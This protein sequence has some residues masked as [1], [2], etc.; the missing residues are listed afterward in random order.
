VTISGGAASGS[1]GGY[2]VS[3]TLGQTYIGSIAT[4]GGGSQFAADLGFWEI[5]SVPLG[6]PPVITFAP[7]NQLEGIGYSATFFAA[8]KGAPPLAYQWQHNGVPIAGANGTSFN[9]ASVQ[10]NDAGT[11]TFVVTDANGLTN[12][13]SATLT[14]LPFTWSTVVTGLSPTAVAADPSGNLFI[15][16]NNNVIWKVAAGSGGAPVPFAG[17]PNHAGS[18]DGTGGDARFN[19]PQGIVAD[20]AGNLYVTDS[21]NDT[22]RKITPAGVVTTLA[23]QAGQAGFINGINN[24]NLFN[25]PMGLGIDAANN[26]YVSDR[27]DGRIC[28][29]SPA[30]TIT[31][32]LDNY[33][34][35][36]FSSTWDGGSIQG[37]GGVAADAGGD[38]Y[39]ADTGGQLIQ[40]MPAGDSP[41]AN[42]V[43]GLPWAPANN[44]TY[45][46]A[47]NNDGVGQAA[48]FDNPLGI[49]V[50]GPG[51]IYVTDV[52]SST[53]R[54]ITSG[55]VVST[56][57]GS[58][59]AYPRLVDG[60]GNTALFHAP[61]WVTLDKWGN[62]YVADTDNGAIRQSHWGAPTGPP[63]IT[64]QPVSQTGQATYT[65]ITFG[66]GIYG[67]APFT[68]QWNFNGT[69][70]AGATGS[71]YILSPVQ[72]A[73]AGNYSVTVANANGSVTSASA[74]LTVNPAY[75]WSTVV[76][77]IS[78]TAVAEDAAGNLYIADNNS[79][80]WKV[81]AGSGGA[82]VAWAGRYGHSGSTDGAGGDAR[83][84]SPQGIA[85]DLAGNVYV[86]DSGNNTIRLITP[87][88]VVTTVAG[89]ASSAGFVDASG[90][91]ARFNDPL[92]LTLDSQTNIYVADRYN[93]AIRKIAPSGMVT[94]LSTGF[95]DGGWDG[96]GGPGPGAVAVDSLGNVYVADTGGQSVRVIAPGGSVSQFAGPTSTVG[97]YADGVGQY[98]SLDN[99][100]GITLDASGNLYVSDARDSTIRRI[101][102]A[103][104]MTT[105]GGL[106]TA[107]PR[108]VD[109]VGSGALFHAPLGLTMDHLGNLYVAD[110]DNGAIRLGTLGAPTGPP[111]IT[112][113]PVSQTGQATYTTITF[114]VGVYGAAPFT[115]Q[116]YFNG[117]PIAGATGSNYILSPVQL[118]NAGTY[119]VTV[120]NANGSVNSTN[121]TLTVNPAYTWS[122]LFSGLN[123][124]AMPTAVAEDAAGNLYIAD[125]NSVIWKVAAGAGGAPVAWA[126]RYGHSGSTD[127]TGGDARFNSPQ[128]IA[129]DN[130]G[131][132]YVADSGNNTIRRI[133][134]AG[135]VTTLAGVAGT[136]A[137]FDG[138]GSAALFNDPLGLTVDSQANVYVADR[139]NGAIRKLAPS[140]AVTTVAGSFNSPAGVAVDAGGSLY[141]VELGNA[142]I[143][144]ISPGGS[145]RLL[146]GP[147]PPQG[148]YTD[149][150]GQYAGFDNPFGITL[151]A[152][153]YVYVSDPR[154]STIR[155]LDPARNV[156]TLGGSP[157]AYPRLVDGVGSGALFHAPLGLTM[158]H[159][160]NLY[161]AD[162]DN[163]AIR[164]GTLGAPTGPPQITSQ[165]VS[166]TGQATYTTITFGV[167]VYGAAPFTYQW[168]F[169]GTP[170]PGATGSNYILS[171]VQLANAG[172]YSVTVANANGSVTSASATLSVNP[173]YTWSTVIGG[174]SPKAVAPDGGGNL[175]I[176]DGGNVIW[177][178]AAGGGGVPVAFAGLLYHAGSADGT[179]ANARFN[180]P[181]G[182]AVDPAGNVYVAD[183]GNNTIRMITPAGAVTT[184]AGLAGSPG[185]ADGTSTA[186]FNYPLGLTAVTQNN[187]VNV[188]VADFNNGTVRQV[189]PG[190]AVTTVAGGFNNPAGV[191]VDAAGNIYLAELGNDDI[192]E[193]SPGGSVSLLAGATPAAEGYADGV[194][195]YAGFDNPLGLAMDAAQNLYVSDPRDGTIRLLTPARV[196]TTIGGEIYTGAW[197]DGTGSAA[198][199]RGPR[200]LS[201][202][203]QGNVYVADSGN[204][205]VRIGT[206]SPAPT[207]VIQPT[208]QWVALAGDNLS[209]TVVAAGLAP[210]SYQWFT[211]ETTVAGATAATLSLPNVTV[212]QSGHYTLHVANGTGSVNST[213]L[214]LTVQPTPAATSLPPTLVP[215]ANGTPA[216]LQ[217]GVQGL[218]GGTYSVQ[219][220]TDFQN[221]TTV[222]TYVAPFTFST[223]LQANDSYQFYR[224]KFLHR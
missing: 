30:G 28:E 201:L 2:D 33:T 223:D 103:R 29:V 176:A 129:V 17:L 18:T 145:V 42:F 169:N 222:G 186:R 220:S 47:G 181:E 146:A 76:S 78:P 53:I 148:G 117:S 135:A 16:D 37:A 162:S 160:G 180:D 50:D 211:N 132:V 118:V 59:T 40:E 23:G 84:N 212:R 206:L 61:Q 209:F 95:S 77:G 190:G 109:G 219:V 194:G 210:L 193:I 81:T 6:T 106:N 112:S 153:G 111:Q 155:R 82:P 96:G 144:E 172:T 1:G 101:D 89:L 116:W 44:P 24:P 88:G 217:F 10:T 159:L 90:T 54:L 5:E 41:F 9:D 130:A 91:T 128:G 185:S 196:V 104:K 141:V 158:D 142:D 64:S 216:T 51:N 208:N 46:Q 157:P 139:Y 45:P 178:L 87:A 191:A 133:T 85:V 107:Y 69:P 19:T 27:N 114:G 62:V 31:T 34:A 66:V 202:D 97:G 171:P 72:L 83:F 70:I 48:G 13:A 56:I 68:Y 52:R 67:A 156:T 188:Y 125:N 168:Y 136:A 71:N 173:A 80:I 175:Y 224:I 207:I 73:N 25:Y 110:F 12:Q 98:A 215:G 213:P 161:V 105:L 218:T 58:F 115:Y 200:G 99:P 43:A 183:A 131:N 184:L 100:L 149:G 57:G 11:Y 93:Y 32:L 147:T 92:G 123:P 134:P 205:A 63:Q 138:P 164:L 166:Q 108:L 151:D 49:A 55:G 120:A 20:Q 221:W 143:Q 8:A 65:T 102:P 86:S 39:I 127:G 165:P 26:L 75:T 182:L 187:Q 179:G 15:A 152:S 124:P 199:Y 204:G 79:V 119:S 122:T 14:V 177:K 3:A 121:A 198:G 174:L 74:T 137:F 163:G 214:A 195:Q 197:Q 126:G 140:G 35:N 203:R 189:A 167:G 60:P 192:R 21:G 113:Q 7:Q 22:L 4:T 170:I 94:T 36:I 38:L 150:V 154:D